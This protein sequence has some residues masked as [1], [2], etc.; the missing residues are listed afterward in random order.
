MPIEI[1]GYLFNFL[2]PYALLAAQVFKTFFYAIIAGY[3]IYQTTIIP[4]AIST[5]FW[6]IWRWV[7]LVLAVILLYVLT[8]PDRDLPY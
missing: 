4:A 7:N 3:D 8:T 6:N 2:N 1:S 5:D